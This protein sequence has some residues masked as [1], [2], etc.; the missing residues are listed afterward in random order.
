MTNILPPKTG[1][2][3]TLVKLAWHGEPRWVDGT[4]RRIYT[5]D[6]THGEF[7]VFTRRGKHLGAVDSATGRW[8][9]DAVAGR[10]IDV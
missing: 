9:K 1:F 2:V 7:E 3:E 10:I 6:R 4:G 5:W 8:I